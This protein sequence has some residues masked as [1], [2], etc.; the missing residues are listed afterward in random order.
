[1]AHYLS[2]DHPCLRPA[3]GIPGSSVPGTPTG[4]VTAQDCP[5]QPGFSSSAASH[6]RAQPWS[7]HLM[8]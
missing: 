1:M 3:E 8:C 4:L 7:P 5:G 6:S 2:A